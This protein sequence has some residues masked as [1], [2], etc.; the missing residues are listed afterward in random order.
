MHVMTKLK[1][2]QGTQAKTLLQYCVLLCTNSMH[3]LSILVKTLM[4]PQ[5][6]NNLDNN[7]PYTK[8]LGKPS[9]GS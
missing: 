8:E 5:P 3:I 7:Q 1:M 6:V 4:Q 2:K 9:L